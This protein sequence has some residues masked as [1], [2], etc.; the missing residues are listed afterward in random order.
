M[1]C[2]TEDCGRLTTLYLCTECIVEL[3]DLLKDVP[4][5]CQFLQDVIYR[6]SVT[7]KPGTG[8]GGSHPKSTPPINFDADELRDRLH[9]L[10]HRAHTEA[11]ENP[12]AGRTLFMARMWVKRART[13]VWGPEDPPIDHDANLQ[14]IK[15]ADIEP[16]PTRELVP[17]LKA[18]AGIVITGMDIRNWA[19]RGKLKAVPTEPHPSYHPHEVIT[20]WHDT[21]AG[22]VANGAR[23]L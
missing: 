1:I 19:R 2:T 12:Y 18:K 10:P 7:R 5:L 22:Q 20:A 9:S 21:R 3:D 14:R 4:T 15:D 6:T 8:G 23:I 13:L 16:M 17:W 11:M